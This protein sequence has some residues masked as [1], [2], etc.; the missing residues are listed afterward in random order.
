MKAILKFNG[1]KLALLCSRCSVIIKVGYQ[2]TEEEKKFSLGEI[3]LPPLF[4][5]NC[6]KQS[7]MNLREKFSKE[8]IKQGLTTL[9]KKKY[10]EQHNI[11]IVILKTNAKYDDEYDNYSPVL[12]LIDKDYNELDHKL[13]IHS[14]MPTRTE[15]A[16]YY[17]EFANSFPDLDITFKF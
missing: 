13:N 6:K 12:I 3:I 10:G 4:C 14:L 16:D 17:E 7:N 5:N 1:G 11:K 15:Q 9:I 8:N 2:F